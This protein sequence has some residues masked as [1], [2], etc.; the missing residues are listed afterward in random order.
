WHHPTRESKSHK[1]A[2]NARRQNLFHVIEWTRVYLRAMTVAKSFTLN[3][4]D[5]TVHNSFASK[6]AS[7]M[8][9][10]QIALLLAAINSD[11]QKNPDYLIHVLHGCTSPS[12]KWNCDEN[13]GDF[14]IALYQSGHKEGRNRECSE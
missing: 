3:M 12:V 10:Q 2:T 6:H 4:S 7:G 14:L 9:S 13:T 1:I 11:Y 5:S 8:R